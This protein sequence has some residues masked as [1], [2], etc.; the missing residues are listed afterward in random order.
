M[1]SLRE[2]LASTEKFAEREFLVLDDQRLTFGDTRNQVYSVAKAL[3]EDFNIQPGDRVAILSANC[4][5]WAV[6]FFAAVS[7]GAIVSAFN[8]WWTPAEIEYGLT[9]SQPKLLLGDTN[10]LKR[11]D[12]ISH[13]VTVINFDQQFQSLLR[14]APDAPEPTHPLTKTIPA[15][16]SIPA[17]PP[18]AP[19]GR[20]SRTGPCSASSRPRYATPLSAA[21]PKLRWPVS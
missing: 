15:S 20:S 8:G 10:R 16:S 17:A 4:P 18:G 5:E 11:L 12:E 19:K 2:L 6:T 14:H 7:I 21:W 1:T 13:D 9:H 3:Q